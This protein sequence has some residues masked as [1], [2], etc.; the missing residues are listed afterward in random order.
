MRGKLFF[1]E[2]ADTGFEEAADNGRAW[3]RDSDKVDLVPNG[4]FK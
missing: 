3:E 2:V 4:I 1:A